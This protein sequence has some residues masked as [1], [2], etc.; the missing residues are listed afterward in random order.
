MERPIKLCHHHYF[1]GAERA[2]N[3][4]KISKPFS[5]KGINI[6][7]LKIWKICY[8]VRVCKWNHQSDQNVSLPW[9]SCIVANEWLNSYLSSCHNRYIYDKRNNSFLFIGKI[10]FRPKLKGIVRVETDYVVSGC[11]SSDSCNP[12]AIQ[13]FGFNWNDYAILFLRQLSSESLLLEIIFNNGLFCCKVSKELTKY[14]NG[15]FNDF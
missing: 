2:T 11:N 9:F 12:Y 10:R 4:T 1:W 7:G 8:A 5:N 14:V 3:E 15:I 6:N 13:L